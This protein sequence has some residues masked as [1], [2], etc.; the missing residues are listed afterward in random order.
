[1]I[2]KAGITG[3]THKNSREVCTKTAF[4]YNWEQKMKET[5]IFLVRHG[6]SLGNAQSLYLGHTDLDLSELG[7]SQA[8]FTAERLKD[9]HIDAIYS[10]DLLRA[11]NTA[12][13]HARMRGLEI[14]DMPEFRE[15]FIGDWEGM[16]ITA[17]K[18]QYPK[19]FF[20]DWCDNFGTFRAPNGESVPECAE[21]FYNALLTLAQKHRGQTILVASHAAIIRSFWGRILKLDP[22][23][24]ASALPFPANASYSVLTYG[25]EG[26]V[27]VS[28]SVNDHIP[29]KDLPLV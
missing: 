27:P 18:E 26:F 13:P 9:E 4:K 15:L 19:E 16:T 22:T 14:V 5:K 2:C 1:M 3:S 28:F 25:D 8:E 6:Q 24:L 21:R 7:K 11:H 17:L 10:S 12:L 20:V 23:E 29:G